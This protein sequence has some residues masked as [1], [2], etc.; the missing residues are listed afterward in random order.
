MISESSVNLN[1]SQKQQMQSLILEYSDQFSRSSHDLGS[2]S[3]EQHTIRLKP[4]TK[5]IKQRPYRIPLAKQ[6]A[7]QQE[8]K[9]MA[10]KGL[11]EPSTSAWCSPVVLVPKKSGSI[12]FCIDFRRVNEA[13]LPDCHPLPR[14][15]D[16]LSALGGGVWFS[17]A[18]ARSGYHQIEI[19]ASDR[20]IT[21]FAIPG[22]GLWHFRV[23]PFGLINAPS[24]FERLMEKI[25]VGLTYKSILI[26]L[27]D[28]I[29]FSKNFET[30]LND[31]R[32]VFERLKAFNIKL[33]PEK[34][35]FFCKEVTFLGHRVSSEGISTDPE[36]V[37]SIRDWP[38]PTNVKEV[39][40]FVG[41]ASYY[42]KFCPSFATVCKPLHKLTEH[43]QP[44]VWDK[45]AQTAFDT[46][47]DLLT[48]APVLSYPSPT[49]NGWVLDCDASN[50]G[51]GAVLHQ[52]QN[53]DEKVIDYFSKCLSRTERKYCTTRKELL[54]VVKAVEHFHHYIY[55]QESVVI[56]TDHSSLRWLM[57]FRN[58]GEG[59][60]ARFLEPLSAYSFKL[61]FRAGRVHM[62]ADAL[63]RRP[64]YSQNCKYCERYEKLHQ[65]EAP[66][67]TDTDD[68]TVAKVG[69]STDNVPDK[70]VYCEHQDNPCTKNA[71]TV[72]DLAANGSLTSVHACPVNEHVSMETVDESQ[73]KCTCTD[74]DPAFGPLFS[75][76]TLTGI[77]ACTISPFERVASGV[78]NEIT[79]RDVTGRGPSPIAVSHGMVDERT[80]K[81]HDLSCRPCVCCCQMEHFEYDWLDHFEE[82]PLFGC[83]FG[84][85]GYG[86]SRACTTSD[87]TDQAIAAQSDQ[88]S[89]PNFSP[90]TVI[91]F[92]VSEN[93]GHAGMI[94]TRGTTSEDIVHTPRKIYLPCE[95][96][97]PNGHPSGCLQT[98]PH[99]SNDSSHDTCSK[100]TGIDQFQGCSN[101]NTKSMDSI[102]D[103]VETSKESIRIEQEK[104]PTLQLM[105]QWK[106]SGEKPN[107]QTVAPYDKE[108]KVYWYQWEVI[109]IRDEILC[110]K[111]IRDDGT[112]TDYL[113]IIPPCL[114]KE[115][116]QHLHTYVT[117]GHLGRSKTYEKMRQRF[118]WCNMHRDVSYWCRICPTCGSRKQPPRR[119][120]ALL[121]QYN[122]GCP[123]ERIALDL[124]GPY[125]VSR[126]GNKYLLVVSCYFSKWLEAI[127]LK[128]QETT[129]I[130]EALVNKFISVHGVPLQIHA[131]RGSNFEAKVFQEVCQLLGI[132]KTRTTI[133]RPQ[134]DGMVERA[135]RTMQ[136]MIAS[137]ISDKQNDWDEHLPLL[138]LAYRSSVH[139]TLGVSPARMI[140]G[141]DLTLPIDLAIGR[142]VRE[143]KHCV[144]DYAYELEQRLLDIHEYAR[145]HLKIASDS[146]KRQ[147]DVKTNHINYNIGNVVWYFKPSRRKG[148]NPKIQIHWKGPYVVTQRL[149]EVLYRIQAGPKTKSDIVHHDAIRPYLCD[150]RP[151]W[152]IKDTN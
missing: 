26:Y 15:D 149:N 67:I 51:I 91:E 34:S 48:S 12:R 4:G 116:F 112:G 146:M 124:S 61:E 117:A 24:V 150:D 9:L 85:E 30:H 144:T 127:P 132:D 114:W 33:N 39:R 1:E 90:S 55:G 129:T 63:S 66:L 68:Q 13:S 8:I 123:M 138:L 29:I 105:L 37:Q 31:L 126:K 131:D 133:R 92:S 104:D 22:S 151:T 152:F 136:N 54:A 119:A 88:S 140:F 52:L 97:F 36:K 121:Q 137:Y 41:L 122:V 86:G 2:C 46:L 38:Q 147:Y 82:E 115:L 32:E 109:E 106:R 42:R 83:L 79:P 40:S 110:K 74:Y 84:N 23:L 14:T 6:E 98:G 43:N 25:F 108:L 94:P 99:C 19:Q 143:E 69:V 130:A 49:G 18:D 141:R 57:N 7:A 17:S 50:V 60:L 59:Q 125:P 3:I 71:S 148:F 111:H 16:T 77:E 75:D 135:N 65:P 142:P 62:N 93:V 53:G 27:D 47:N 76:D 80:Q 96:N 101:L 128:N 113:Y 107:W 21:A 58:T 100:E 64:C 45:D 70:R 87:I 118:Y 20:P 103:R 81:N 120:K 11:I 145:K 139:E 10:E 134:S 28:L 56:R 89:K 5:P 44:F 35:K 78:S 72:S 73:N 102:K 95:G